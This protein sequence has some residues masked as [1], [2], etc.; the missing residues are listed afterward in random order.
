VLSVTLRSLYSHEKTLGTHRINARVSLGAD[1]DVMA[2]RKILVLV[3]ILQPSENKPG[4][5]GW[6][7]RLMDLI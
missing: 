4:I 1:L 6:V 5:T 2:K 7:I 3:R